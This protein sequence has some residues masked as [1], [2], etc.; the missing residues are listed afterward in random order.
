MKVLFLDFDGVMNSHS[1]YVM[2]NYEGEALEE[3]YLLFEEHIEVLNWLM[4]EVP[5][6]KIIISSTW[7]KYLKLKE[8]RDK[9]VEK[10][11]QYPDAVI[12]VTPIG[13]SRGLDIK[14][15][16]ENNK[17]ND[18]ESFIIVD[19]ANIKEY[20]DDHF[21][22][23]HPNYGFLHYDAMYCKC[24]LNNDKDENGRLNVPIILF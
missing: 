3:E 23:I 5:D 17:D 20:K 1:G 6:T 15:W 13:K 24:V 12:G 11:F 19:D 21:I 10:G 14:D 4:N 8:M 7:R 18:I 16:L 2:R 22:R 9:M